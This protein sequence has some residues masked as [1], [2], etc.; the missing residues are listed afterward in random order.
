MR[1]AIWNLADADA[2]ARGLWEPQLMLMLMR[3]VCGEPQL[4]LMRNFPQPS[5]D[6][7]ATKNVAS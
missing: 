3:G 6:A 7:D 2:D 5:A 1:P 4:M